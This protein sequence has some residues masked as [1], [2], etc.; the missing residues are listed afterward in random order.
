MADTIIL[1]DHGEIQQ[2]A[3]PEVIYNDPN[4]VFTAQFIGTPPM[5][6]HFLKGGDI[7]IGYRPE[8]VQ[9][10]YQKTD[11]LYCRAAKILTREM[12]GSETLYKIQVENADLE[13]TNAI[14]MCKSTDMS[15]AVDELIYVSVEQSD[16][17]YFDKDGM[18]IR[19]TNALNG[20]YHQ[21]K[22]A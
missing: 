17:Y 5:N 11:L 8:K 15:F 12:L 9:M 13:G 22:E 7:Q 16:L 19:D 2:M 3:S 21:T 14:I 18:R 4:N 6:I 20:C 10:S 1:M